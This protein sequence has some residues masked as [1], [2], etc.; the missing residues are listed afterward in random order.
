MPPKCTKCKRPSSRGHSGP[1]D[2]EC[3]LPEDTGA[4]PY[5]E[6]SVDS[7]GEERDHSNDASGSTPILKDPPIKKSPKKKA[8]QALA[9]KEILI[10]LGHLTCTVQKVTDDSKSLASSQIRQR[11]DFDVLKHSFTA[12]IANVS[13]PTT[14][15]MPTHVTP[16][17][18]TSTT[19]N[20]NPDP[21]SLN[22]GAQPAEHQAVTLSTANITPGTLTSCLELLISLPNGARISKKTYLAAR[23]A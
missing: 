23:A 14:T 20:P 2:D 1:M 4:S 22:T 6:H 11:E 19:N 5:D 7:E 21:A 17:A 13:L 12:A 10:Q 8:D 3:S 18:G 9:M 15:N 16:Q